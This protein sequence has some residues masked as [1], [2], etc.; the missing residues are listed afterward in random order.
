M[1]Y[2][3]EVLAAL[4]GQGQTKGPDPLQ[5]DDSELP[6][7]LFGQ[8]ITDDERRD[9][10]TKAYEQLK[11]SY[12]KFLRPEGTKE[13]PAKT[14]RDLSYTH[15]DLP[16]G[17]YWVDPNEGD[18]KDAIVVHC[19]MEQKATCVLAQPSMT[20]EYNWV[21][22]S[23]GITWLGEDIVSGFE[24]T[25]KADSNQ[26]R[27]LQLLSS[28]AWQQ[29]TYHCKNSVAVFD[30]TRRNL[31]KA[32]QIMTAADTE[33]KAR[34]NRKFRYRVI[35]DGCRTRSS[36]WSS[37]KIEYRTNKPQRLPF[38][39]VGLRDVGKADQ[40]FKIELSHVCFS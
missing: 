28:E 18:V 9:L 27:F 8:E 7:R 20:Q 30:A 13:S 34:G 21:G 32:M 22:G 6:A 17:E 16:S 23:N 1:G 35:E 5:G 14:C 26:M 19:D 40:A 4:L 31:R 29:L 38:L 39:D 36:T 37:T 2:G 33:L 10:I 15:P 12:K 11:T 25:Y 3:V 24:F